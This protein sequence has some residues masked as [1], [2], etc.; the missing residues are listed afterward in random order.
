M[1]PPPS[2][3]DGAAES[4]DYETPITATSLKKA[5]RERYLNLERRHLSGCAAA[6]AAA[7]APRCTTQPPTTPSLCACRYSGSTLTKMVATLA[8]GIIIGLTAAALQLAV[9]LSIRRRNRLLG[10][11]LL[12]GLPPGFAAMLGI[13]LATVLLATL[14]VHF[15]APKAGG[16]GVALVSRRPAVRGLPVRRLDNQLYA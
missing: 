4:L 11:L 3:Y 15:C 13:S 16:G 14:A 8:S 7:A 10:T 12:Q 2:P 5:E 6:A 9:D 1:D